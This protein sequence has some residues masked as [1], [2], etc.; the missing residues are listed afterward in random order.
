MKI[1]IIG[2]GW[3]GKPLAMALKKHNAD[4][5]VTTTSVEKCQQ[6]QTQ[7]LNAE[8]LT[9]PL[10]KMHLSNE[11]NSLLTK[12]QP[13]QLPNVFNS[14]T[15]VIAIPPKTKQGQ[16]D[17]PTNIQQ[18]VQLAN[19]SAQQ[20]QLQRVILLSST[21][22]YPDE[23][24]IF[25]EQSAITIKA[26]KQQ[27]LLHA[28]QQLMQFTGKKTVVRLAGLVNETRHPGRFFAGKKALNHGS[29][30]VNLIHQLDAVGILTTLILNTDASI[31]SAT[32]SPIE[33]INAVSETPVSKSYFYRLAAKQLQL[34]LPEF[35]EQTA[36]ATQGK[37]IVS[38]VIPQ[39]LP[40]QFV[41]PNLIDWLTQDGHM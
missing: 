20:G 8:V 40:Y 16:T 34:P 14:D 36:S 31:T 37:K 26:P 11:L 13:E 6:L 17:Y 35:I 21:A 19:F 5:Y 30:C 12:Q 41:Y 22:V 32:N 9:F 1:G 33:I 25:D 18:I 27:L 24:K 10:A 29:A 23:S 4:I 2:C 39:Q 7:G 28:E 3:L 38:T 15:L